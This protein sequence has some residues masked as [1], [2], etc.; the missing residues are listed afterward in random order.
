MNKWWSVSWKRV[1]T[2]LLLVFVSLWLV[3]G[4]TVLGSY[5]L[6]PWLTARELVRD[7]PQLNMVPMAPPDKSLASLKGVRVD[8]YGLSFQTPWNRVASK[9]STRSVSFV[10]FSDGPGIM[11]FDPAEDPGKAMLGQL[12]ANHTLDDQTLQSEYALRAAEMAA[13]SEQIKWWRLPSQNLKHILPFSLKLVALHNHSSSLY[14]VGLGE[15][16]GFQ[17]G[18]PSIAPYDVVLD[19]FDSVDRH[20]QI[21]FSEAD[22]RHPFLTQ[23][24]INS[25]S[26]SLHSVP[27][28]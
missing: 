26:A 23:A 16:R 24:E 8:F 5:Q 13:T 7:Y 27:G 22:A 9:R 19:L 17:E 4:A 28:N 18:N 14:S 1:G 2:G 21:A 15:F 10:K 25:M 11:V 12:R 6:H 3:Y 20:Y